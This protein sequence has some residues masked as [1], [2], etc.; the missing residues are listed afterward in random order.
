M[1][2]TVVSMIM[3]EQEMYVIWANIQSIF[4]IIL[5]PVNT[6]TSVQYQSKAE[7]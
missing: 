5:S 4:I 2:I 6:M 1:N 7:G 3:T